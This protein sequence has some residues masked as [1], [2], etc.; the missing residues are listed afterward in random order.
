M[1][2]KEADKLAM[3]GGPMAVPDYERHAELFRWPIITSEDEE[4][5]LGVLRAG[6][7]SGI[8]VARAF[9]SEWAKFIGVP[10]ALSYPN[11]TMAL[12]AAMHAVGIRRGDEIIC[13]SITYWASA[14]PAF[15]L[16]A[17]VEFADIDPVSLCIDPNDIERHIYPR[18]KAIVVVHYCGHPCDM[19]AIMRIA[20]RHRLLVIEDCSHS[21]GALYRGRMTGTFGDV[22]AYSMMTQKSFPIGEGGMLTMKSRELWERCVAFSHYLR[23][24]VD[25]TRPELKATAGIALGGVKGR[26]NQMAAAMGRV[27]L[28]HMPER[29]KQAQLS[30]N[31]FWDCLEGVPGL[32]P[33]RVAAG[34]GSTMGGW[35]NPLGRYAP[36]EL[37]G[38]PVERFI[39]AVH[40]EG[41]RANRGI[42]A[43]LHLHPVFT[44]AD[45]YGD[46]KPTRQ[47]FATRVISQPPGSLPVAEGISKRTF[48]VPPFRYDDAALI[49]KYAAAYRKVA[50]Q[51]SEL[52]RRKAVKKDKRKVLVEQQTRVTWPAGREK[53][54]NKSRSSRVSVLEG[55]RS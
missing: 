54:G 44:S 46:G 25:L 10:Y 22:A 38:L 31:R 14:M 20:R 4:A 26:L 43:P 9:E 30:L 48:G 52:M 21:H 53:Q 49:T 13:P 55:Y 34:S 27:Q 19:D 24:P 51:A 6:T 42:N 18:T 28:R 29:M 40:A 1:K 33:H 36:E 47:A 41:V 12:Q 7:M 2:S 39:E 5:V 3:F 16:G 37:G 15:S 50:L 23:H 35:Y 45:I 17:T 8:E 11:G 32:Y